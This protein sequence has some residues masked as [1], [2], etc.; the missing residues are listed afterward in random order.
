M[1][2]HQG[3]LPDS[4]DLSF[5][6]TCA[7]KPWR[8]LVRTWFNLTL[9]ILNFLIHKQHTFSS[10]VRSGIKS[11]SQVQNPVSGF[12]YEACILSH[13]SLP[14][15]VSV[16]PRAQ[17]QWV[18]FC[19]WSICFLRVGLVLR[20]GFLVD[21]LRSERLP[22]HSKT[23][24]RLPQIPTHHLVPWDSGTCL[25]WV[26]D[27]SPNGLAGLLQSGF[28]AYLRSANVSVHQRLQ[29][30]TDCR[31]VVWMSEAGQTVWG[32]LLGLRVSMGKLL[33]WTHL[34]MWGHF[35][36][37]YRFSRDDKNLN[38]YVKL[39]PIQWYF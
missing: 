13:V 9:I 2:G 10:T 35:Y 6:S 4:K 26:L 27:P 23:T 31:Q 29:R 25:F 14:G 5:C 12:L 20:A 33:A 17:W 24:A 15:W 19:K 28:T 8:G 16:P 37:L 11:W 36:H 32:E 18:L 7:V 30:P 34:G 22:G 38:F 39:V 3:P 1:C 21:S